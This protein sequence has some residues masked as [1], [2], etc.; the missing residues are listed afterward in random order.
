M[1][2]CPSQMNESVSV[3]LQIEEISMLLV[4]ERKKILEISQKL[5][6]AGLVHDGQGN[7]SIYNRES[8][9][10]AITPSAVPYDQRNLEDICVI[11]LDGNLIESNWKPTQET[12]LHLIYYREREDVNAVVHTHAPRATVFGVIGT[13]PLPMVTNEAAMGAGGPVPIAPYARPG[14]EELAEVTFKA[15]GEGFAAIMA[16]HGLITVGPDINLAYIGTIAVESTANTI[17]L[18]RSMGY[19]TIALSAEEV[20]TLRKIFITGYK[21]KRA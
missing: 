4:E 3:G 12:N 9:L 19:E 10:I 17:I 20:D 11:D 8:N 14:S 13:E 1:V 21:P 5:L 16:H 18:A 2:N 15:T 6:S 7:L